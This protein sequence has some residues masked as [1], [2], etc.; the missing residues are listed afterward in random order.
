MERMKEN[1]IFKG[2][3]AKDLIM[4]KAHNLFLRS[5]YF[6]EEAVKDYKRVQWE[7]A[8]FVRYNKI[9]GKVYEPVN[10]P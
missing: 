7:Y 8:D 1:E 4:I 9:L 2:E 3:Y 10:M 6:T 5:L